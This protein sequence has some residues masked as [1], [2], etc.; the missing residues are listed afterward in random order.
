[1]NLAVMKVN[2]LDLFK[3][4]VTRIEQLACCAKLQCQQQHFRGVDNVWSPIRKVVNFSW[5]L[6]VIAC[7]ATG[8]VT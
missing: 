5:F 1:L 4:T 7:M 3:L 8:M 2:I 6:H